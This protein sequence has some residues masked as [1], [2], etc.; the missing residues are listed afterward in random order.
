MWLGGRAFVCRRE[1]LSEILSSTLSTVGA[2]AGMGAGAENVPATIKQQREA[3]LS[4][5]D[6]SGRQTHRQLRQQ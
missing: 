3:P 2:G 6:Q 1:I 4:E 5:V